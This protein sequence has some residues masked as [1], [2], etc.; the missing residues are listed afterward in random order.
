MPI[1]IGRLSTS[2]GR[3][4]P[5]TIHKASLMAGSMRWIWALWHQTGAQCI[6]LL[7]GPRLRWLFTTMLLQWV[8][9]RVWCMMSIS[10]EV[11][12]GV[13]NTW[14]TCPTSLWGIWARNR[15]ARF[16]NNA[17]CSTS[18]IRVSSALKQDSLFI[19]TY[20][21]GYSCSPG[22]HNNMAFNKNYAA[23][24]I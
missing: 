18:H 15:R 13:S 10:C 8:A 17:Q 16:P 23:M 2:I 7:S 11:T 12:W 22:L 4:H 3:M 21:S 1:R 14:A 6:L 9:S 24:D 5:V 20:E 19:F